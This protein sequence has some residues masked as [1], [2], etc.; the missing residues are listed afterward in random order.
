M[1]IYCDNCQA[2]KPLIP[3]YMPADNRNDHAATDLL[4]GDCRFVI[5]TL[6]HLDIRSP[7][8]VNLAFNATE[9]DRQIAE[10][11]RAFETL[12]PKRTSRIARL[13]TAVRQYVMLW[14]LFW[15]RK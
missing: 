11:K 6:H 2:V 13:V 8:V 3:A 14:R 4:C 9:F 12:A 5:A 1:H 7:L 10:L 15:L